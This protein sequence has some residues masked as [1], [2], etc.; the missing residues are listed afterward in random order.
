MKSDRSGGGAL[1]AAAAGCGGDDGS[2]HPDD[3]L[4]SRRGTRGAADGAVHRGD[5]NRRQGALRDSA[6]LAGDDRRGGRQ[7]PGRR[8][9]RAGARARSAPS[10]RCSGSSRRRR[11]KVSTQRFSTRR[12]LGRA[13][14]AASRVLVYNTTELSESEFPDSVW[15]LTGPRWKGRV[16]IAPTNGSFQAFV[17]ALRLSAG[18]ERDARLARGPEGERR[19]SPSR[20]T[21]RSSRPSPW[22]DRRR[23]RQ[24]LLPPLVGGAAGRAGR[25]HFLPAATPARS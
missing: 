14:R 10:T 21:R 16:G 7:Q 20:T 24:P 25:N 11:S 6:E 15:G 3:L 18:E 17:T 9:L 4:G 8:L 13:P 19:R 1:A 2:E 5:R 12:A 22:R 23:P